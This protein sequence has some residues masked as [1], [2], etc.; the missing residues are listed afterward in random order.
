VADIDPAPPGII[1]IDAF[2]RWKFVMQAV[3]QQL[4]MLGVFRVGASD[5]AA[6][7]DPSSPGFVPA[8]AT[9]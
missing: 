8:I 6:A 9:Q 5:G 4:Q 1:D 2:Q 3:D 7:A